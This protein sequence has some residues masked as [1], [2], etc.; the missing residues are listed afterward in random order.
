MEYV[1]V[2]LLFSLH[3]LLNL[4]SSKLINVLQTHI[5]NAINNKTPE[6]ETLF[7]KMKNLQYI[8]KFVIRSRILFAK[9]ND[10]RDQDIFEASL[11]GMV[12]L[13]TIFHRN[14]TKKKCRK[15]IITFSSLQI[16]YSH[17]SN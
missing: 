12:L 7:P 9:L 2:Y 13:Q 17:L 11:E 15:K 1:V 6:N 4:F 5:R 14:E 16:C 10:D 3:K 8:M